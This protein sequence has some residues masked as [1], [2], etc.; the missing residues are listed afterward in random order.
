MNAVTAQAEEQSEAD[1]EFNERVNDWRR[2]KMSI[3]DY[4]NSNI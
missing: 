3:K 1:R 4:L 2:S